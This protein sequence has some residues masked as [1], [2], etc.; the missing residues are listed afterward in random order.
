MFTVYIAENPKDRLY[1][2]V[3]ANPSNRIKHH[4]SNRGAQFTSRGGFKI[5]FN[6]TYATLEEARAREVQIKK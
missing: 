5:V 3:T 6:E 2:G 1:T 4:N